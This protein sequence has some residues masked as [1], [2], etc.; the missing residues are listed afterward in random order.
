M[1]YQDCFEIIQKIY[2]AYYQRPA[3][4]GGLIFWAKMLDSVNGDLTQIINAFGNSQES[5]S[6]YGEITADNIESVIKA[7]YQAAFN[8][9]P[10]SE[11][12]NF[13][14]QGFLEGKFTPASIALNIV[15]GARGVDAVTLE[16]KL[17]SALAFTKA[18]DPDLDGKGFL[19]TYSGDADAAKAREWLA[20]VTSDPSTVKTV[21]EAASF[22]KESIADSNDPILSTPSSGLILTA[23]PS[24]HLIGTSGDDIFQAPVVTNA[25]GAQVDTLNT[26]DVIDGRDGDDKLV[27]YTLGMSMMFPSMNNVETLDIKN[28]GT[29][30][31]RY[32]MDNVSGLKTVIIEPTSSPIFLYDLKNIVDVVDKNKLAS[33]LTILTI[34]YVSDAVSGDSDEQKIT[35]EA[36]G[37]SV[38]KENITLQGGDIEK[39]S[40]DSTVSD[41]Y[42]LLNTTGT[43]EINISGDAKL[44]LEI[45]NNTVDYKVDASALTNSLTI[46]VNTSGSHY[47]ATIIGTAKD[48]TFIVA[49]IDDKYV[50][51][52]GGDGTDIVKL[53]NVSYIDNDYYD[54]DHKD[55]AL[56]N[57]EK[58]V[59]DKSNAWE[60]TLDLSHQTEGFEIIDNTQ[61]NTIHG[62]QGADTIKLAD[63]N[64][65]DN[66][67]LDSPF[68]AAD[69]VTD[70]E[71]TTDKLGINLKNDTKDVVSPYKFG[72]NNTIDVKF[73]TGTTK[74]AGV[75]I[76]LLT[77]GGKF[78]ITKKGNLNI[79][80]TGGTLLPSLFSGKSIKV[81]FNDNN[82][83]TIKTKGGTSILSKMKIGTTLTGLL[84]FYDTD[85]HKLEMYG[86]KMEAAGA[87][88]ATIGK[89]TMF[90][91]KTIGI[92]SCTGGANIA[93]TDIIIF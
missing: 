45:N 91:H 8:R 36:A 44:D 67:I 26:T 40:I 23:D 34:D 86:L 56:K 10:E 92:I 4:P 38:F 53:S 15:N 59:I 30:V 52:D 7:I 14:K 19:A 11:G 88:A 69:K 62:G 80:F 78:N 84:F 22:I 42:V 50:T 25:F 46:K 20:E 27:V 29:R 16:N 24:D 89:L 17:D 66:V 70:F 28:I 90:T 75:K 57:V 39:V 43:T 18:I 58:I 47:K 60:V 81:D 33:C 48:D 41:N 83:I 49:N 74:S 63:D 71:S 35:L 31:T 61:N 9:E 12:L 73:A 3:D 5:K 72:K 51:F 76:L 82:K 87:A 32:Y 55:N 64:A 77:V 93:P 13:Y 85:D 65:T 68:S 54:S 79:S 1:A 37:N 21:D 2:I 6:L